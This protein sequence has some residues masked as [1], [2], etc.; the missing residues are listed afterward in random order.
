MRGSWRTLDAAGG[1]A[2]GMTMSERSSE[3]VQPVCTAMALR[4]SQPGSY[5]AVS[6]ASCM[7]AMSQLSCSPAVAWLDVLQQNARPLCFV[8]FNCCCR[9]DEFGR[10][11]R[12]GGR[13]GGDRKSREEAALARLRGGEHPSFASLH[14]L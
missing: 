11:K 9:Y 8:Q 7:P 10:P 5:M 6:C 14:M 12:R 1:K 13:D 3:V 4:L 2:A